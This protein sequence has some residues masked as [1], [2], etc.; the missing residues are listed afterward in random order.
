LLDA[1]A[2]ADAAGVLAQVRTAAAGGDC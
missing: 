2:I 1:L